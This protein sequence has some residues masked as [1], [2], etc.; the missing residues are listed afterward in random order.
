ME[1]T[2]SDDH[3]THAI[4]GGSD[5]IDFGIEDSAFFMEMLSASLYKDQRMAVAREVLCNADD[6]HKEN[7]VTIPFEVT[8]TPEKLIIRDFGPGI[9]HDQIGAVYGTYGK[10]TKRGN[11]KATGGFGLG[12]KSPFAYTDNFQVT[13][14]CAGTKTVYRMSKSDAEVGG[15]PSIIKIVS[16]PTSETGLEVNINMANP[17]DSQSFAARIAKVLANGEM[18][19]KMNG[20]QAK[21]LPFSRMKHGYMLTNEDPLLEHAPIMV[22][23]GAVIYPISEHEEYE[24]LYNRTVD[25]VHKVEG[26]SHNFTLILQAP[27]GS[28][29]LTPSRESLTITP[30]TVETV[31]GLLGN[32]IETFKSSFAA[33]S[34]VCYG[35]VIDRMGEAKDV[36]AL[37]SNPGIVSNYS[38]YVDKTE[39]NGS[40]Y[41]LDSKDLANWQLTREYPGRHDWKLQIADLRKRVKHLLDCGASVLDRGLLQGYQRALKRKKPTL[42]GH[43]ANAHFFRKIVAPVLVEMLSGKYKHVAAHMLSV[44]APDRDW[45][46]HHNRYY[47]QGLKARS[48]KHFSTG[49]FANYLQMQKRV[50]VLTHESHGV[51]VRL[52][53]NLRELKLPE[54]F[55]AAGCLVY[56]VNRV[57]AKLEE[58]R[59]FCKA[60]KGYQF[61]DMTAKVEFKEP[62]RP[63]LVADKEKKTGYATLR[64]VVNGENFDWNLITQTNFRNEKPDAF[65]VLYGKK[66]WKGPKHLVGIEKTETAHIIQGLYGHRIAAVMNAG[67]ITTLEAK[68]LPRVADWAP[69][70]L[71]RDIEANKKLLGALPGTW[72]VL[73]RWAT[74]HAVDTGF[75]SLLMK[76]KAI[77]SALKLPELVVLEGEEKKLYDAYLH[78]RREFLSIEQ[79]P[80]NKTIEAM[81]PSKQLQALVSKLSGN[82]SLPLLDTTRVKEVFKGTDD[83]LKAKTIKIIKTIIKG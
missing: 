27:P 37:L 33:D 34:L 7:G 66:S 59:E 76:N 46:D 12:C 75:L 53:Y 39:I 56:E 29:S 62:K 25:L 79:S 61:I 40:H 48:A 16:V 32:F 71:V 80:I 11:E 19:A 67:A 30:K 54:D 28:L 49:H 70:Q 74:E 26:H 44:L 10:S 43:A 6:A 1:V 55:K 45:F 22:R 41:L 42:I 52:A 9:P 17:R 57:K 35:Q 72:S 21:V 5:K 51:D 4:I 20:V 82:T 3:I 38:K 60:L 64:G 78:M 13:S 50:I 15:K 77:S 23:Y 69:K 8:L 73:H 63:K 24:V 14:Y 81:L 83:A 58:A 47:S 31:T 65:A 2:H 68:G 36:D 18:N